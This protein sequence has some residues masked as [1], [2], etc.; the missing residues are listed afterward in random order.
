MMDVL[1]VNPRF[2]GKSEIPP[3]GLVSLAATLLDNNMK[4]SVLDLDI[5]SEK[6]ADFSLKR[7]LEKERPSIVGV[8][9]LSDSFESAMD[10]C[11]AVKCQN[12]D[13]LTVLGGI[14]PS[15]LSE[16]I[17]KDHEAVDVVVRG[18]GENSLCELAGRILRGLGPRG[19]DGV[20]FR[21]GGKIVHN[22]DRA[23][24]KDLDLLTIPAHHLLENRL[25]WTRSISS[26]RGC[27][28]HCT[29]CS[30]QSQYHHRVRMRST[31]SLIKEIKQLVNLGAKRIMFTDDNFTF[32]IKRI[33]EL[34]KSIT[35]EGLANKIEFY[36]EGRMDDICL[37]PIMAQILSSAGFRAI[38]AGAESG[39]SEILKYYR[40][41][42]EPDNILQGISFCVEQ[43][44]TPVVNFILM[45]PRDTTDTILETISLARRAFENG[46]EIAYAETLI[47]YPGTP[48]QEEL[49][50]DG[51]YREKGSIFYFES[52]EGIKLDWFLQLC[53]LAREITALI[54]EGD[55]HYETK[56]A[57]YELLYLEE[58][59]KK[60]IPLAL[61]E[62]IDRCAGEAARGMERRV[63]LLLSGGINRIT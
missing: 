8:T 19:I 53:E 56:K 31:G 23:F 50:K 7:V 17:L 62:C 40:K 59:L 42:I 33:R 44:L 46:A 22:R 58:M 35:E 36:A 12:A 18:E 4:V 27:V 10:V 45:G 16:S 49:V 25:Y 11:H 34:C 57:Y 13:T 60:R 55:K 32:S 54:H 24:E 30:I 21:E 3:L 20:S 6:E 5:L 2:N 1:L 41:D 37:N 48:I 63:S 38:Y 26:S 15:V 47:P 43:N 52:Y 28:H 61:R 51:K 29:F 39:S 9:S 14:H